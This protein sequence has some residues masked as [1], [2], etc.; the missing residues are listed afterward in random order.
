VCTRFACRWQK[1]SA[2]NPDGFHALTQ[3]AGSSNLVAIGDSV[4]ERI[5]IPFEQGY[6]NVDWGTSFAIVH[7]QTDLY[8][9]ELHLKIASCI[10]VSVYEQRVY[11]DTV[12]KAL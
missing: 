11:I 6:T 3:D 7:A 8:L 9:P 12:L 5:K 1:T 10:I 2:F 4:N